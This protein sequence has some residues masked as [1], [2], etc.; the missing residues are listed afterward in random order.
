[1]KRRLL[2]NQTDILMFCL[3]I[4]SFINST[5]FMVYLGFLCFQGMRDITWRLKG[6][7]WISIRTII[8]PGI[9]TVGN[10]STQLMKW[11]VIFI[12]AFLLLTVSDY[13][14]ENRNKLNKEIA[15]ITLFGCY[16]LVHSAMFSGYPLTSIFKSIS[17][18]FIY[19]AVLVGVYRLNYW[20][21]I[22]SYL[23]YALRMLMILS[24]LVFPFRAIS[25]SSAALY[26]GFTNQSNM[27]GLMAALYFA[28]FYY[29]MA[30][31]KCDNI[32]KLVAVLTVVLVILSRSRNGML[33]I[34]IVTLLYFLISD[35]SVPAKVCI[36]VL[37][38]AIIGTALF[39]I[40]ELQRA[41]LSFVYKTNNLDRVFATN[42]SVFASREIQ[43]IQFAEKFAKSKLFGA[44]FAV[45]FN[46][47]AQDWTLY[48]HLLV[49][50][51]NIFMALLG[52]IGIVGLVLFSFGYF[53]IFNNRS[54]KNSLIMFVA[55]FSIC[56]GEMV[57]F[58]TNNMAMLLYIM[59]GLVLFDYEE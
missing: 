49:E 39:T 14:D 30:K 29:Q 28:N 54:G 33:T 16:L 25:F 8:H 4:F 41:V 5:T 58:S 51:G 42:Q 37:T 31:N 35:Y 55:P 46:H 24:I 18:V 22:S 20:M 50:P 47:G 43:Q 53:S 2:D 15:L 38:I 27:F 36:S 48:M 21:N 13:D 59:F 3:F 1:M 11:A 23:Y 34:V 6:L 12:L 17:Y 7:I 44:G 45:P 19:I 56:I 26:Q 9:A 57:F 52:D 10:G 40:P 32:D